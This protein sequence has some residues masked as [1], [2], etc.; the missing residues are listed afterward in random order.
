M[1]TGPRPCVTIWSKFI[2]AGGNVAFFS[3]N[4][5]CW[6]VRSEDGGQA[7][8]CWKQNYHSDPIY[9]A[10]ENNANVVFDSGAI[11]S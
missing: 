4:T 9:A 5:C 6:Q 8:T 11:T 7:L 2:A 3:G 1:N 10:R